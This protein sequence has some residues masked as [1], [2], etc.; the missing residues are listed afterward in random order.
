MDREVKSL[1]RQQ[2]EDDYAAMMSGGHE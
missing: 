1:Q 2:L